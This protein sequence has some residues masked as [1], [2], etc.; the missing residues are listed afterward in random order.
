MSGMILLSSNPP[1]FLANLTLFGLLKEEARRTLFRKLEVFF[2][3]AGA[4]AR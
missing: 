3:L 1:G 4:G 2:A